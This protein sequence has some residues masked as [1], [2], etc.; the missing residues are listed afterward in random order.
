[1]TAWRPLRPYPLR[2]LPQPTESLKGLMHRLQER[3]GIAYFNWL[4]GDVGIRNMVTTLDQDHLD[5]LSLISGLP[6]EDLKSHQGGRKGDLHSLLGHRLTMSMVEKGISRVC[7]ECLRENPYHR[8]AWDFAPV[9]VCPVHA[10]QIIGACPRCRTPLHW[11]R[12]KLT[13]CG[14]GHD[15]LECSMREQRVPSSDLGAMRAFSS[16]LLHEH[17]NDDLLQSLSI[18]D[19]ELPLVDLVCML[20]VLASMSMETIPTARVGTRTWYSQHQYHLVANHAYLIATDWPRAMHKALAA[21]GPRDDPSLFL[22][23]T[24]DPRRKRLHIALRHYSDRPFAQV[25]AREIGEYATHN[26]ISM[27]P[28]AFGLRHLLPKGSLISATKASRLMRTMKV[29]EIAKRERWHGYRQIGN[30]RNVMLHRA[31]VE[32]WIERNKNKPVTIKEIRRVLHVTPQTILAMRDCGLFGEEAR[33]RRTE[34][35]RRP[36]SES[37]GWYALPAELEQLQQ[38][39]GRLPKKMPVALWGE[40]TDWISFKRRHPEP[41]EFNFADALSGVATGDVRAVLAD[42]KQ[43]AKIKFRMSDLFAFARRS[44][45]DAHAAQLPEEISPQAAIKRFHITWYGLQ[46]AIDLGI[47]PVRETPHGHPK[48]WISIESIEEFFRQFTTPAVLARKHGKK[49][50]SIG[51]ALT[52][53]KVR[54]FL[55]GKGLYPEA[56]IYDLEAIEQLGLAPFSSRL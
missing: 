46:R 5:R 1:M 26:R 42:V 34:G 38:R 50:S 43:L 49:P 14:N 31:D 25:I 10:T 24:K 2:V 4:V 53:M 8:L 13:E 15:L 30:R 35:S 12:N 19:E 21:L 39:F 37:G 7:V 16:K 52:K 6:V 22:I 51:R 20:D 36:G 17:S 27:M 44:P 56:K 9:T 33:V 40:Y 23:N 47:L 11:R 55:D 32:Y 28:G 41:P 18:S 54:P 45:T 48:F 29:E 3:N